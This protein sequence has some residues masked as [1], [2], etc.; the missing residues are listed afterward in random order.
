MA[1]SGHESTYPASGVAVS[2]SE[3]IRLF[4]G[5]VAWHKVHA[6][7]F[8]AAVVLL[9]VLRGLTGSL[10]FTRVTKPPV[11]I[12]ASLCRGSSK[13][14]VLCANKRGRSIPTRGWRAGPKSA[15]F[16]GRIRTA[17]GV[18]SAAFTRQLK[19]I[20]SMI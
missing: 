3:M 2:S 14:L 5:K 1:V 16:H 8:L 20:V 19:S 9:H 13:P 18:A 17:T 12:D 15:C 7:F 10:V 6:V 4:D 11:S